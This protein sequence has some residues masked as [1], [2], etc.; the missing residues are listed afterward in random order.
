MSWWKIKRFK[1]NAD[2][3]RNYY[4]MR[5]NR[6]MHDGMSEP[7]SVSLFDILYPIFIVLGIPIVLYILMR[8]YDLKRK[9]KEKR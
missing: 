8:Y 6:V 2:L 3:K 4:W 5:V 1:N 7:L 9:I